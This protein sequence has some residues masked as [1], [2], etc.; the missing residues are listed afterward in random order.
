MGHDTSLCAATTR[1][2]YDATV[3]GLG[4][5]S[6]SESEVIR[7]LVCHSTKQCLGFI[8]LRRIG[9]RH[10]LEVPYRER[11]VTGRVCPAQSRRPFRWIRLALKLVWPKFVT[12]HI[13][14]TLG[15]CMSRF[16]LPLTQRNDLAVAIGG[17]LRVV[18]V[19]L[20]SDGLVYRGELRQNGWRLDGIGAWKRPLVAQCGI[21][22]AGDPSAPISCHDRCR[23]TP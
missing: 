6:P 19:F 21:G 13:E 1:I 9:L 22:R 18:V 3:M 7:L 5:R 17:I 10:F 2:Q 12:C 14:V 16:V 20:R 8:A 23:R 4:A 11:K 15:H